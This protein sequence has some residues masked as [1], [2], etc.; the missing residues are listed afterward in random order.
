MSCESCKFYFTDKYV[1]GGFCRR[2]PPVAAQNGDSAL[3]PHVRAEWI[4]GE[5]VETPWHP[6]RDEPDRNA[7]GYGT[8]LA[9]AKLSRKEGKK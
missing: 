7:P 9:F 5:W 2:F 3:W 4:C 8:V 6:S 1:K